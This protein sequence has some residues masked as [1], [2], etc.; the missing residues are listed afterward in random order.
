MDSFISIAIILGGIVVIS[1]IVTLLR[2]KD[3]TNNVKP[4]SKDA[5]EHLNPNSSDKMLH[6]HVAA[7]RSVWQKHLRRLDIRQRSRWWRV[8][9]WAVAGIAS[10]P[11][12][13]LTAL[14][15]A[16]LILRL[17][18]LVSTILYRLIKCCL[19][20]F[21]LRWQAT[22]CAVAGVAVVLILW[23]FLWALLFALWFSWAMVTQYLNLLWAILVTHFLHL[24]Q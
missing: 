10:M 9:L 6:R 4:K 13:Y 22:F 14:W 8:A 18:I 3:D 5:T 1:F 16:A 23:K 19:T 24:W 11:S 7:I 17:M 20:K 21:S 12:F 15:V 2:R